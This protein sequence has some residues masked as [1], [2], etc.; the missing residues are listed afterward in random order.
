M[1]VVSLVTRLNVGGVTRHLAWLTGGLR[2]AGHECHLIAGT[3]AVGEGESDMSYFVREHGTEPEYLPEM[4]REVSLKDAAAIWKLYRV[5]CRLQPD[6]VDTHMTKAG[7][8]G[9]AAGFLYRWLTPGTLVGSP[10]R[11]R[12]VHTYHG[13]VYHSHF[14][15]LKTKAFLYVERLLTRIVSDRIIVVSPLQFE[16][17]HQDF[18]VGRAEQFAIVG[19]GVDPRPFDNS[20]ARRNELRD[21][22]GVAPQDVLVGLIGRLT[23]IKNPNLFLQVAALYKERYAASDDGKVKFVLIGD[24]VLRAQLEHEVRARD[25]QGTVVFLGTR[26]DPE[27]FYPG[28]DIVAMTSFN[29]GVPLA[30]LEALMNRRAIISTAAGGSPDLLGATDE[31]VNVNDAA[32]YRVCER[33]IL[34]DKP[35]ADAYCA[36]LRRLIEDKDLR[37]TLA[38]RGYARVHEQHT[39]DHMVGEIFRV[40]SELAPERVDMRVKPA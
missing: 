1:K 16:Q 36:G 6:I 27:V 34:L 15:A 7:V 5:F 33:G 12:F 38:R 32:A 18:G 25:L 39:S 29:E 20:E 28:L 13:H 4:G 8:I 35:D 37:D 23:K 11:V 14:G 21:E 30:L 10:R 24:G 22:L 3:I 17:V 2:A 19:Y 9:R 31:L 26:D 40:F